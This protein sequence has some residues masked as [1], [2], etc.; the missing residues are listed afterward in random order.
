ML[1][2]REDYIRRLV[3]E[4]FRMGYPAGM[5]RGKNPVIK[6]AIKDE[7][8]AHFKTKVA[9]KVMSDVP[10]PERY[11]LWH[12]KL[13]RSLESVFH[14]RLGDERKLF[15]I[16]AKFID[17][18]M[19]QMMKYEDYRDLYGVIF[20]PLDGIV[21][22]KLKKMFKEEGLM[23]NGLDTFFELGPY[24]IDDGVY[25]LVQEKLNDLATQVGARIGKSIFRIDLNVLWAEWPE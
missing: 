18:F 17:T 23:D 2:N 20:L 12:K 10:G 9:D 19:H 15:P 22:P 14:G 11:V 3:V 8:L 4:S 25:Y 7:L 6:G 16:T 13:C 1:D 24:K 5:N 21:T